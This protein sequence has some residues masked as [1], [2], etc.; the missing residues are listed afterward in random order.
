VVKEEVSI[1]EDHTPKM[2]PNTPNGP[3]SIRAVG[4]IGLGNAGYSMASNLPKAGYKLVVHDADSAKASKAVSE[5]QH[6][7]SEWQV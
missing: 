7:G 6:Y 1:Q 3:P 4:Y 5:W 2:P